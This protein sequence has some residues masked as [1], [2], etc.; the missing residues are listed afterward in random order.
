[1]IRHLQIIISG[2]VEQIGFR[3]YALW[4]AS[5]YQIKG[6]VTE[7]PG[8]IVIEA[9]GDEPALQGF[10]EWC[11]KGPQG[12][13]VQMLSTAEKPLYGYTDFRIL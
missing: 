9:E 4:G 8:Q 12:S 13:K 1:M 11:R 6:K 7:H 3:L 5:E 10:I 2:K